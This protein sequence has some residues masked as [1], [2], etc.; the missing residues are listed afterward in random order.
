MSSFP[1]AAQRHE[2]LSLEEFDHAAVT[3][4]IP[5]LSKKDCHAVTASVLCPAA[6][7]VV[8]AAT[9]TLV[10]VPVTPDA[11]RTTDADLHVERMNSLPRQ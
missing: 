4:R 2:G 1:S 3:S 11:F 8:A 10:R 9:A 5:Q 7:G 6:I